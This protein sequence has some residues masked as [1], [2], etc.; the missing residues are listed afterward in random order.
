MGRVQPRVIMIA[1]GELRMISTTK[2]A[3]L[4]EGWNLDIPGRFQIQGFSFQKP[5]GE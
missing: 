4:V 2:V 5:G 3:N 1:D